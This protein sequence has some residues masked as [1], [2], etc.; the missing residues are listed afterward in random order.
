MTLTGQPGLA[1]IVPLGLPST[2]TKDI[3]TTKGA[4]DG[5][6][7]RPGGGEAPRRAG[8]GPVP[9]RVRPGGGGDVVE[10]SNSSVVLS[11]PTTTG[12]NVNK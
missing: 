11:S 4:A 2:E 7:S 8:A 1:D 6:F 3:E 5:T 10:K 12:K 9:G